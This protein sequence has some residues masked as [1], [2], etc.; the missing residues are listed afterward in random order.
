MYGLAVKLTLFKVNR[1]AALKGRRWPPASRGRPASR[2][3]G[4]SGLGGPNPPSPSARRRTSSRTMGIPRRQG[5]V[6]GTSV[7]RASAGVAG[8]ARVACRTRCALRDLLPRVR[9]AG[10]AGPL[11]P[12][13][14]SLS[15]PPGPRAGD[16]ESYMGRRERPRPLADRPRLSPN[17][18]GSPTAA[19]SRHLKISPVSRLQNTRS[20][21]AIEMPTSSANRSMRPSIAR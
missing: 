1:L 9:L 20:R 5:R 4:P 11:R 14:I 7:G 6:R 12:R 17:P 8:G 21:D 18:R 3:G 2:R 19:R 16:R 13:G 15:N 10:P